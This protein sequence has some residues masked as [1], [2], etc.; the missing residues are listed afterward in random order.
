MK[1]IEKK[2]RDIQPYEHNPRKNED[3]V[4]YVANSI[5]EFGFKVPI[6]VDKNNVIVAGH[7]RYLA[8]EELGIETVPCIVAD[9]L[10]DEQIRAYRIADNKVADKATWDTNLLGEE[11]N[12][13]IEDFDMTDFGFGEF[14]IT[15]LT[16]D[17]RADAYDDDL[18]SEYTENADDYLKARRIIIT[19][20]DEQEEEWLKN[21][22]CQEELKVSYSV[23]ELTRV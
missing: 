23:E 15:M 18:I 22:L 20:K 4:Q 7:T 11:L 8:C 3:A 9:D 19:Y 1:I 6:V 17:M 13:L 5:R 21:L 12:F 14:E 2:L 10:T 16:E